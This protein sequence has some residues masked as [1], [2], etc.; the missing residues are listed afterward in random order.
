MYGYGY[1][2]SSILK[3]GGGGVAPFVGLLDDYP[4]AAAAYS[5]RQLSSSYSG[6]AIRVRRAS[7]NAELN[8]GFV[9]NELDTSALT[10]FASGTDGF[11]TTWYDQSGNSNDA[12]QSTAGNQPQIVSSG[13]VNIEGIKP[14]TT[15]DSS[16]GFVLSSGFTL[17]NFTILW[18]AK[19]FSTNNNG[20]VLTGN[21]GSQ[22]MGDDINGNGNPYVN[23]AAGALISISNLNTSA[24]NIET[25]YHL[26]YAN[27]R[28]STESVGQF[29]NS[30]NSYNNTSSNADVNISRISKYSGGDASFDYVGNIQE[31]IIYASDQSTNRTGISNNINDFY[32]IY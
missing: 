20:M 31:I 2:Y 8:I 5:L 24:S 30:N 19:R 29:N 18:V 22:F 3:S 6:D 11:V 26:S 12:T 28:N 7:D 9:A 17:S 4:S 32:S 10:T 14:S 25:T 13:S 21:S 15:F 23:C 16:D 1:Q 27:R